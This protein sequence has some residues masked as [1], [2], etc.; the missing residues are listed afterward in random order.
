MTKLKYQIKSK[1]Q[2]TE[3]NIKSFGIEL[4]FGF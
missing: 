3:F 1:I 4:A 2:M